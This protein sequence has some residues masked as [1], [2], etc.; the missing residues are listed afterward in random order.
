MSLDG[1]QRYA[2]SFDSRSYRVLDGR[3]TFAGLASRKLPKLYVV[4]YR[5]LPIYVGVTRQLLSNRF[6]L[7]WNADG[8]N[9]YY[10]YRFRHS[11][12]AAFVDVWCLSDSGA[13]PKTAELEIETI[14]AE[15]VYL[16]RNSTGQ[17]PEFQNEIHF[18]PSERWHRAEAERVL[19]RYAKIH[20]ARE[21]SRRHSGS[22]GQVSLWRNE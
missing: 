17:W 7:G 8:A 12:K 16:I 10:G 5:D 18:H 3:G 1:P 14:E 11:L 21:A 2:I 22:R 15:V 13:D 19:R 9:G 4:V 6:R 20:I